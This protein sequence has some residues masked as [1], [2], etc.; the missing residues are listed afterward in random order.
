MLPLENPGRAVSLARKELA[1]GAPS[2]MLLCRS[3]AQLCKKIKKGKK[4][5]KASGMGQKQRSHTQT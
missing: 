5:E 3:V 2:L 4:K 1:Q